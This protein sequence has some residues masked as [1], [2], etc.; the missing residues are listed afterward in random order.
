MV[1]NYFQKKLNHSYSKL[2]YF[3]NGEEDKDSSKRVQF[4]IRVDQT[5][6]REQIRDNQNKREAGN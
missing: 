3:K 5:N 1:L 2:I 6:L 4:R